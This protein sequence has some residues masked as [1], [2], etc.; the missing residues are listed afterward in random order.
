MTSRECVIHCVFFSLLAFW[1]FF[2]I[3]FSFFVFFSNIGTSS[4][5]FSSFSLFSPPLPFPE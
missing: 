1:F 4:H 5:F 3:L 2:L